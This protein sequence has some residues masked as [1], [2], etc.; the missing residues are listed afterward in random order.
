MGGEVGVMGKD[1][2][3][4]LIGR[5]K[6]SVA[7]PSSPLFKIEFHIDSRGWGFLCRE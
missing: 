1:E 4:L 2:Q 6:N 5:T 7:L 3:M